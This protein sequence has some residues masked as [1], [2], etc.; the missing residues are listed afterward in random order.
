MLLL[1]LVTFA[2]AAS[3]DLHHLLHQDAQ[4]PTHS[5]VVTQ[6]QQ[7][8]VLSGFVPVI[9]PAAPSLCL[10]LLGNDDSQ[11]LHSC[12]YRFSPSRA[13]PAFIPPT[14]VAG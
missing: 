6:V 14:T 4:G 2:L 12:D 7:H 3:P 1:W 11:F 10:G 5:C 8:S 13:P 9:V